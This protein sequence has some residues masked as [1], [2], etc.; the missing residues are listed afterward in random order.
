MELGGQKET[1]DRHKSQGHPDL[2]LSSAF[3]GLGTDSSSPRLLSQRDEG[4]CYCCPEP[5]S[6][7]WALLEDTQFVAEIIHCCCWASCVQA[8]RTFGFGVLYT[9]IYYVRKYRE[10][11]LLQNGG[12]QLDLSTF[13]YGSTIWSNCLHLVLGECKL[14]PWNKTRGPKTWVFFCCIHYV[15]SRTSYLLSIPQFLGDVWDSAHEHWTTP[16][17]TGIVH[18]NSLFNC[19]SLSNKSVAPL[20]KS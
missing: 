15:S 16:I 11:S 8:Q 14:M 6:N 9:L 2:E 7:P 20:T 1:A 13:P 17:P 10:F 18:I 19:D 5:R 12:A 4:S 3:K